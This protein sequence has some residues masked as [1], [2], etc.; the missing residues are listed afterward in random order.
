MSAIV[1][2]NDNY[3]NAVHKRAGSGVIIGAYHSTF[4][5]HINS[6]NIVWVWL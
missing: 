3:A 5:P 2:K 4:L 1:T 6:P